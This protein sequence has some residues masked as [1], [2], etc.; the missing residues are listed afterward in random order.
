MPGFYVSYC[1]FFQAMCKCDSAE[2]M[3]ERIDTLLELM[4]YRAHWSPV[5]ELTN[6]GAVTIL[7]Q[8]IAFAYEWN[9]GGR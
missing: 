1:L 4:P 9:F 6:L 2:D 3:Q 8:I 5:D 7:L